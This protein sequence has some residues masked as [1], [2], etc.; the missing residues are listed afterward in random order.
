MST[1]DPTNCL[2]PWSP[3]PPIL[4]VIRSWPGGEPCPLPD[5]EPPA[6]NK[7]R[8]GVGSWDG[9]TTHHM[10]PA[11]EHD[12]TRHVLSTVSALT[13]LVREDDDAARVSLYRLYLE[14]TIAP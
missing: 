10:G 4:S 2:L 9:I 1:P 8:W 12:E 3:G 6:G 14:A 13:R 5:D 11:P 7:V